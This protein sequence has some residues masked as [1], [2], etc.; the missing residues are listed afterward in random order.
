MR[1]PGWPARE[2][3]DP[4]KA[5]MAGPGP[6][7]RAVL[8]GAGGMRRGTWRSFHGLPIIRKGTRASPHYRFEAFPF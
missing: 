6:R 1:R 3:G 5:A 8:S 4:G 7:P 2:G